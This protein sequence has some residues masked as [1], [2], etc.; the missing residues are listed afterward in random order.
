[1]QNLIGVIAASSDPSVV[2][3]ITTFKGHTPGANVQVSGGDNGINR[4][5]AIG[6]AIGLD[7]LQNLM[8]D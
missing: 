2:P 4:L 8:T 7:G 6:A 1:M 5:N 3:V